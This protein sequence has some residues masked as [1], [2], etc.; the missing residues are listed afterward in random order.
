MNIKSY[1]TWTIIAG[2]FSILLTPLIVAGSLFFPFITGKAFFFR[3]IVEILALLWLLRMFWFPE[4]RPRISLVTIAMSVFGII[5]SLAT[6]FSLHPMHSFWSNFERMEGLVTYLHLGLYW[7]V[8]SSVFTSER[9]WRVFFSSS[10][11]VSLIVCIYGFFQLAGKLEIHQGSVRLDATLGNAIYLAVYLL[12]HLFLT[13]Y[14]MMG[15]RSKSWQIIGWIAVI[16]QAVVLYFTATRGAILG[17]IGGL[18]VTGAIL[19]IRPPSPSWRR[20]SLYGLGVIVLLVAAFIGLR[21]AAFVQNSPVLS[22]FANISAHETTT[23]SRLIIWQMSL[24]GFTEH[25]LL[26]WGPENYNIVFNK[27]YDPRLWPQEQWFDRSHNIFLDWLI[28]AGALGLISYLSLFGVSLYYLWSRRRLFTPMEYALLTGM[29]AAYFFHNIFVFDNLVSYIFFMSILA[30]IHFRVV[31]TNPELAKLQIPVPIS[32]ILSVLAVIIFGATVY[33]VVAKPLD[34]ATKLIEALSSRT[35]E[36]SLNYF[37]QTLTSSYLGRA[38]ARL[39]MLSTAYQVLRQPAVSTSTKQEFVSRTIS[40]QQAQLAE[41][42]DEARYTLFFGSFLD[43][44]GY[45]KEGLVL[46]EKAAALSPRKQT[47]KFELISNA[48]QQNQVDQALTIAKEAFELDPSFPEARRIYGLLL[49][50]KGKYAE[51]DEVLTYTNPRTGAVL[52][53]DERF[54]NMYAQLK[55]YDKVLQ[56]WQTKVAAD[57]NNVQ[58]RFS[59]AAAYL[60]TGDRGAAIKEINSAISIDPGQ[61]TFGEQL[62]KEIQAGR[63]PLVQ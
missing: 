44:L 36:A 3:L 57:P 4:T 18:I 25:P 34:T 24:K 46:L 12:I 26:G 11:G 39:Q 55:R 29:L 8:L 31:A 53:L 50:Q 28:S 62:I 9:L 60:A 16:I 10:I 45:P 14:L 54:I 43:N 7:L 2:C 5:V 38:E 32:S 23:E 59:L 33:F 22:R 30:Y 51:A 1:L 40:E 20:R 37:D 49:L 17:L 61:R 41:L 19:I 35:A 56:L 21:Q 58:D 47:I 15:N 42:P 6:I 48:L 13:L 27:Y 63:N 52:E